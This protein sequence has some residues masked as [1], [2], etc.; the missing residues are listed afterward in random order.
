M[1]MHKKYR[2]TLVDDS[3]LPD[4]E[5]SSPFTSIFGP[6]QP[7]C[8]AEDAAAKDHADDCENRDPDDWPQTFDLWDGNDAYLGRVNVDLEYSPVFSAGFIEL[9]STA[10][11]NKL[12]DDATDQSGG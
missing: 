7:G 5:N 6:H 8:V 10:A 1:L 2:Y 12:P 9:P 3:D 11:T 4:F